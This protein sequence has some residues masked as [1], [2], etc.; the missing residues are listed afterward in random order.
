MEMIEMIKSIL[1]KS[2]PK[3]IESAIMKL[4]KE[5]E[6]FPSL[7]ELSDETGT[8]IIEAKSYLKMF[9]KKMKKMR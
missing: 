3:Q 1:D 6:R 2:L 4:G 9:E 7:E 5:Y 8:S